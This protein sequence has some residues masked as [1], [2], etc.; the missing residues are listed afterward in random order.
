MRPNHSESGFSLVEL[1]VA[2]TLLLVVSSIV[3]G[4][5]LQMT[6][7]Q[8]TIWNRTE[9]HSGVRGA[10]ELL[11]QEVGQAGRITLPGAAGNV[12]LGAAIVGVSPCTVPVTATVSTTAVGITATA[13]MFVGEWLTTLDGDDVESVV[14]TS[15]PS[16]TTFMACFTRSHLAT[17]TKIMALGGFATGIVPPTVVNGST[18]NKLKL[19]GDVNGDGTMTYIEYYCDNGFPG[20]TASVSTKRLGMA[21]SSCPRTG[22]SSCANPADVQCTTSTNR[23]S[24]TRRF[25]RSGTAR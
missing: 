18:A 25:M 7:S 12:T 5:L 14:I 22:E 4:A 16:S 24:S 20:T 15:I 6:N 1:L 21:H 3:T 13:H 8:L 10:T 23:E 19:Y 17:T 9:M 11:Q 2:T